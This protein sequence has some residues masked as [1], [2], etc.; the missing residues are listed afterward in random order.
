MVILYRLSLFNSFNRAMKSIFN[1]KLKHS[2][3]KVMVVI[4]IKYLEKHD[5]MCTITIIHL[6]QKKRY[7]FDISI[8][9]YNRKY[10]NRLYLTKDIM[11]RKL[12]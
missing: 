7:F 2:G 3:K 11:L 4:L 1:K 5:K 12:Y 9:I 10:K 6:F 8:T